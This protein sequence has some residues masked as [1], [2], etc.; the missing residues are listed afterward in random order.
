MFIS[1]LVRAQVS[2]NKAIL[3]LIS[4]HSLLHILLLVLNV[5]LYDVMI[6]RAGLPHTPPF[7]SPPV[8]P[9]IV[10]HAVSSGLPLLC[11]E[12]QFIV[13]FVVSKE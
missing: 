6:L 4:T 13:G 7:E 11:P 8:H 12:L 10:P 9:N 5:F 1:C 2:C 3:N